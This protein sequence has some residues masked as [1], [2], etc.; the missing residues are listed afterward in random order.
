MKKIYGT[1]VLVALVAFCLVFAACKKETIDRLL[2]FYV[3]DEKEFELKKDELD[4]FMS[5]IPPGIDVRE[6]IKVGLPLSVPPYEMTS[7]AQSTYTAEGT[8]A[9]LVKDVKLEKLTLE[10]LEPQNE[11]FSFLKSIHVYIKRPQDQDSLLLAYL[12]DIPAEPGNK[13]ELIPSEQKVDKYLKAESYT[14][15]TVVVIDELIDSA[16]KCNTRFRFKVT[17]DPL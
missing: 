7:S 8:T 14:V 13:L 1:N 9:E 15:S 10:L 6:L 4:E 2:T 3:Q 5:K 17:A 11:D 12:D 16:L